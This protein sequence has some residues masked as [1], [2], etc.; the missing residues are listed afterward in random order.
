ME[1]VYFQNSAKMYSMTI[2]CILLMS[3][4]QEKKAFQDLIQILKA[5]WNT[6][7]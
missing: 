7:K 4:A 6:K 1:L 2:G 5:I 3:K